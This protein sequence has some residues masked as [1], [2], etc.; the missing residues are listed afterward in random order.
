MKQSSIFSRCHA[1][2]VAVAL[3]RGISPGRLLTYGLPAVAVD[4]TVSGW[5]H[6]E[7]VKTYY[8]AYMPGGGG[9]GPRKCGRDDL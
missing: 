7:N 9:G 6:R 1:E 5:K 3:A 2:T 4:D 8:E